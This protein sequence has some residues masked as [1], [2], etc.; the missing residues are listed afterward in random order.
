MISNFEWWCQISTA[1]YIT[2]QYYK[3]P[4]ATWSSSCIEQQQCE[5]RIVISSQFHNREIQIQ[6]FD[7]EKQKDQGFSLVLLHNKET[8]HVIIVSFLSFYRFDWTTTTSTIS[9]TLYLANRPDVSQQ[10]NNSTLY[11]FQNIISIIL[12]IIHMYDDDKQI[13]EFIHDHWWKNTVVIFGLQKIALKKNQ[14]TIFKSLD[15]WLANC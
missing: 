3:S 10:H 4:S 9:L 15:F 13:F 8:K 2:V 14:L 6:S 12:L 5:L 7:H 1:T 11:S